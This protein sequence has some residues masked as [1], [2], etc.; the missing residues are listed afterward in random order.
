MEG[1][2]GY[3]RADEEV[4]FA[5]SP[6]APTSISSRYQAVSGLAG[7]GLEFALGPN[8]KARPIVLAGYSHISD[9]S[10]VSG[11]FAAEIAAAGEGLAFNIETDSLLFGGAFALQHTQDLPGDIALDAEARYTHVYDTV[12][13]ASD[14]LLETD[15]NFDAVTARAEFDG[16]LRAKLY[17]RDLRWIAFSSAF[18]IPGRTGDALGFE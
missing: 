3:V 17:S 1:S 10:D 13:S 18:W 14:P 4:S 12:T 16:P 7:A 11:P 15:A 5:L 8:T 2:F 6:D 9:T